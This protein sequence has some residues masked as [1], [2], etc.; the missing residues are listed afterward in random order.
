LCY[1]ELGNTGSVD[2]YGNPTGCSPNISTGCLTNTGDFQT[3][4]GGDY[5]SGTQYAASIDDAWGFS[6]A[7][8]YQTIANGEL[9]DN[10]ENIN[11]NYAIAVRSG[12]V[13][14]LPEPTS[15]LLLGRGLVGVI[16]FKRIWKE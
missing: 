7:F 13:T 2:I 8:G 11:Y 10:G 5:W 6:T 4:I 1:T 14:A 15:L 9:G 3:L 12:D 16:G